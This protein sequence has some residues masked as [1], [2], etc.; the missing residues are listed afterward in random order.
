LRWRGE[1]VVYQL[2]ES[3]GGTP[4]AQATPVVLSVEANSRE[5][6]KRLLLERAR[7][8]LEVVAGDEV[9]IRN[10]AFLV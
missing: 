10:L 6:A 4:E 9:A 5:D 8:E 3:Q 7:R 1:I 2:S